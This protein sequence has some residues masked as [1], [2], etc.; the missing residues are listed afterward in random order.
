V[1]ALIPFWI[2]TEEVI[3]YALVVYDENDIVEHISWDVFEHVADGYR[4]TS[5]RKAR[6]EAGGFLFAAA[7]EGPG[8]QRKEILLALLS[9]TPNAMYQSPAAR[10]CAVLFFYPYATREHD[11][12]LDGERVGEMPLMGLWEWLYDPDLTNLFSRLIVDGGEHEVRLT[13][14]LKP[15]E[16]SRKLVCKP[17]SLLYVYPRLE[18]VETEPWGIWRR[19]IKYEGEISLDSQPPES[20]KAWKQLLFYNGKWLDE[21]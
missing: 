10:S 15:P 17:G 1:F 13:T 7:K 12:F 16:F 2:D 6:L 20:G 5:V 9:E 14:S 4:G 11:Y 19:R 3:I 8:K 18:L 21:E